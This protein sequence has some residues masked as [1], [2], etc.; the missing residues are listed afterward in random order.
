MQTNDLYQNFSNDILGS[1]SGDL[2]RVEGI[3]KGQQRVLR[4]LLTN[5][6]ETR[7]DGTVLPPDYIWHPTYGAGLGRFVGEPQRIPELQA[8]I[9]SQMLLEDCVARIPAPVVTVQ[10]IADGLLVDI[11]YTD[12]DSKQ[13]TS[14]NFSVT[15]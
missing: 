8:L 9:K 3:T 6:Q 5:P 7:P 13:P 11:K 14:L 10:A 12:A 15:Q 1:P 2:Q 4:R